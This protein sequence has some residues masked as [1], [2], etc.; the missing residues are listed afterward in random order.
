[1]AKRT[2]QQARAARCGVPRSVGSR[3][4]AEQLT[5]AVVAE[6]VEHARAHGAEQGVAH[7]DETSGRQGGKRAWVWGAVTRM[8]TVLLLRMSRGGQVARE[9]RGAHCGGILGPDRYRA[10]HGYPVR[11]RQLCWAPLLRDCA[12][13]RSRGGASEAIGAALLAQAHPMFPWWHR[14]REGRLPRSTF[15][16]SLTP[17]RREVARLLEAGS[18]CSVATTEGTCREMLKRRQALWTFGQVAGGE[19]T[20]NTAARAIRPGGQWRTSSFCPQSEAGS[21]FVASMMTV[22]ATLKHQ[23]RNGLDSLTIAHEAAL[24]GEAAP[25]LLPSCEMPSQA[26]A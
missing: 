18:Q 14:G 5:T 13:M 10:Y 24:H 1:M 11:W 6:P 25:A 26:A 15:R 23:K 2:P 21:R 12:A 3:S 4:P 7:R 8:G 17:L 19:P 22:V 9:L 16:S 20:N